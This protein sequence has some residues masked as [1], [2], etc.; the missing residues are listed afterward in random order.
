MTF[1]LSGIP[2]EL[3]VFI[4]EALEIRKAALL[5]AEKEIKVAMQESINEIKKHIGYGTFKGINKELNDVIEE[6]KIFFAAELDRILDEGLT[7]ASYAG[8]SIGN[9]ILKHY[10]AKGLIKG[11]LIEKDIIREAELIAKSTMEK[12][13]VFKNKE[14]VLSDRIWDLSGNNYE[15][16][17]EIISSGINT[18]CVKVAK[19]L[20]QYVKQGSETLAKDYPNM[21]NRMGG[22][23][24]KNLNYEALRLARNELSEV[25]WQSTIEGY[26]DNPAI[27][28]VKWLLSNNRI[29]GFHDVCDELA[30]ADDFGLGVGIYPLD[31]A[32]EKPHICCLCNLAPI[33]AD[34]IKKG[35]A[36]N[37]PPENWEEI[38]ERLRHKN[39]FINMDELTEE[40]KETLRE[41]RREAYRRQKEKKEAEKNRYKQFLAGI[42]EKTPEEFAKAI[43]EAKENVPVENA[44]R[45]DAHSKEEYNNIKLFT[46]KGGSCVAIKP[47]GDII[48]VC[49]NM[50]DKDTKGSDLIRYAVNNGGVKLDSYAGNHKF[51]TKNGFEP[52][53]YVSFN[54]EY[55]PKDWK[56]GVKGYEKEDI[57]FY[58]YT[59][60]KNETKWK[61]I[62]TN[63]KHF[64]DYE[65]AMKYRDGLIP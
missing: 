23:V 55:A 21:Y 8:L 59:G 31:D 3:Q 50:N 58:K 16:I 12:K 19:A 65:D 22:R 30:Y 34:D 32:P 33:I 48:S 37:K 29:P 1:D 61:D 38:K 40:Q 11:R 28:A 18:D 57:I 51:Y 6:Q 36:V 5:F 46:T 56:K 54:E 2:E 41:Q 63:I 35:D 60:K 42:G 39:S 43:K 7:K 20:T 27:K 52:V 44:W 17:K 53:S 25:Y 45:V 13:R 24:P 10:K 14:F 62:K 47:D 49:K 9:G 15:K 64:A 4:K 26:K